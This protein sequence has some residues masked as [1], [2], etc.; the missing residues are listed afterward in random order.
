LDAQVS[1]VAYDTEF[2]DPEDAFGFTAADTESNSSRM[3][4]SAVRRFS[5]DS[6]IAF[7]AELE[8]LEVSDRSVFGINLEGAT[9]TTRSL[10]VQTAR[11]LGA[12][13]L[14]IG[15]RHDDNDAFGSRTTPKIGLLLPVG[16]RTT[17]RASWGEGFRA[18]SIGE[19]FY[20]FSGNP[21]LEPEESESWEVGVERQGDGWRVGAT[22]FDSHLRNLIDFDFVSFTNRNVGRARSRGFEAFARYT[23]AQLSATITGTRLRAEDRATGQPLLRRPEESMS[24]IVGARP[25]FW[26]LSVTGAYVGRRPDI[27]PTAFERV[28]LG[29]HLRFDVAGR[30]EKWQ[31]VQPYARVEN[32]ADRRYE[33][34][35]GFPAPPR[36]WIGGLTYSW[37]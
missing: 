1:Q 7:G 31:R 10:F 30:C 12:S 9:Q 20:P 5:G 33:E 25:G 22:A 14:D 21:Q 36:R 37:D 8:R 15:L 23:R 34:V 18:P 35:A 4:T 3:R 2:S 24:M 17:L 6:W 16:D 26:V 19:L 11:D 27:D 32:V 28:E 29:S 13:R